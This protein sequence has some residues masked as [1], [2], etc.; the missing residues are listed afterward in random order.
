MSV[1][2]GDFFLWPGI[3][4]YA[5]VFEGFLENVRFLCGVLLVNFWWVCDARWS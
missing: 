1:F 4:D 3:G 5:G 2:S